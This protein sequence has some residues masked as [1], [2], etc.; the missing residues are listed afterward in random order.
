MKT[1][2]TDVRDTLQNKVQASASCTGSAGG[3]ATTTE[4]PLEASKV[5]TKAKNLVRGVTN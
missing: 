5:G 3:A 1:Y 2:T 4:Q